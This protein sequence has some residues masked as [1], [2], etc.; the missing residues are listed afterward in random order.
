MRTKESPGKLHE[1]MKNE[2]ADA[3]CVL[4]EGVIGARKLLEDVEMGEKQIEENKERVKKREW[5]KR[6]GRVGP[7]TIFSEKMDRTESISP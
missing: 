5:R 6:G 4:V 7:V 2:E 1:E 3:L